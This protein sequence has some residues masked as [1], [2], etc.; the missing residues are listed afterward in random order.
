MGQCETRESWRYI[1]CC[2]AGDAR[3][4]SERTVREARYGQTGIIKGNDG[5]DSGRF[6]ARNL[7]YTYTKDAP[8]AEMDKQYQDGW[9]TGYDQC[10]AMQ[11]AKP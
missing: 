3:E 11:S 6:S 1:E 9:Q 5:C 10:K 7:A 2:V 4:G 8:R